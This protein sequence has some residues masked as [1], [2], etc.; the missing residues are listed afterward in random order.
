MCGDLAHLT[1]AL[2]AEVRDRLGWQWGAVANGA[3][4]LT[5]VAPGGAVGV[6]AAP[7]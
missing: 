2:R 4:E 1:G 3:A 5:H 6:L 7:A